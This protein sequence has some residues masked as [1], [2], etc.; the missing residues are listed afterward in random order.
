MENNIC[1]WYAVFVTTGQEDNVKERL[2][3]HFGDKYR[4]VVPK[5]K[6]RERKDG[7]WKDIVRVLFPGYVL[8]NGYISIGDSHEFNHIPGVLKLLKNGYEPLRI[9]EYEIDVI[10]R[11]SIN[12]DT[13]GFS[14]V[15]FENG[16]VTVA[17]GPLFSMEGNIIS[18]DKR[19][20]R[21]KVR[22]YFLGEERTVELGISILKA[23]E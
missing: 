6:L 1:N 21:A 23:A 4:I 10:S 16:K 3:Y 17:D 14:E 5:R 11:L 8:V 12:D 20:G 7:V 13:I 2:V 19:K 22:L 9:E 18:I 15:L